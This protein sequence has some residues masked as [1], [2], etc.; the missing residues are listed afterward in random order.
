MKGGMWSDPVLFTCKASLRERARQWVARGIS[1]PGHTAIFRTTTM[2]LSY[3]RHFSI[4]PVHHGHSS[5]CIFGKGIRKNCEVDFPPLSPILLLRL[6]PLTTC[7]SSIRLLQFLLI[8]LQLLLPLPLPLPLLLPTLLL[9]LFL[10]LLLTV[11]V[12][13]TVTTT[14]TTTT[15]NNNN[16]IW[17]GSV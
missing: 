7:T 17:R 11:T 14:T 1:R 4:V 3:H 13:V 6:H 15:N 10:F 12:T 16:T 9:L 8:E 2:P 5:R